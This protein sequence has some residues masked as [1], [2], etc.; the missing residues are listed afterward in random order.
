MDERKE[1][2]LNTTFS[3]LRFRSI[4][5]KEF[6]QIRRDPPSLAI[7]IAMPLMMLLLFGYAVNTDIDHLPLSFGTRIIVKQAVI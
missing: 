3:F 5:I 2:K 6:I 4:F 1:R 7:A